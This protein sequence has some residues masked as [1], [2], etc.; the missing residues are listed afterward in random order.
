MR[1]QFGDVKRETSP[2]PKTEGWRPIQ[3][4]NLKAGYGLAALAGL[5]L[6]TGL[7]VALGIWSWVAGDRGGY[8]TAG[9][10]ADPWI[11]LLVVLVLFVPLHELFHLL[12]QPAWGSSD[13]TVVVLWPAKLRFGVYYEGCMSRRRWLAM[14]LAPLLALSLVPACALAALQLLARYGDLEMGLS[15]LMVLNALGSGGDVVAALIVIF[16]V[17]RAARLCFQDGRAYWLP[18]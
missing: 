14:R 16:Q 12:G 10:S 8:T 18:T 6:V 15:I 1:L 2:S 13:Q 7:C 5:A 3:S 17:P 9:E 11:V 4:P